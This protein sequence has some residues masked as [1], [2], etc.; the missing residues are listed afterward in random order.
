MNRIVYTISTD[1]EYFGENVNEAD[2]KKLAAVIAHKIEEFVKRTV[3]ISFEALLVS[4]NERTKIY[5]DADF[6]CTTGPDVV[7][8]ID[9]YLHKNWIDWTQ[10]YYD[11]KGEIK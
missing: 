1:P 3:T 7:E 9:D 8:W 6:V 11:G 4:G 10:I 5:G 2:A